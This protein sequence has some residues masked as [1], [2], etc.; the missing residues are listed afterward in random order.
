MPRHLHI[1]QTLDIK[2]SGGLAGVASLHRAML[3]CGIVSSLAYSES[4]AGL[5]DPPSSLKLRAVFGNRFYFGWASA[6]RLERAIR[7]AEIVH[8]HGLYTYMNFLAGKYCRKYGKVLVCHPHGSLGPTYLRRGRIKKSIVLWLFENRNIQ[9]LSAWRALTAAESDQIQAFRPGTEVIVVPNGVPIPSDVGRVDG[10]MAG[11]S[12]KADSRKKIFLFV[13]RIAYMKGLDILLD[14]WTQLGPQLADAELWIAG[15]DFDGTVQ[16]LRR[17]IDERGLGN[18]TLLGAVSE[19]QKHWLLRAADVF[20]LPSR[21]E[22]Q[23]SAILEAMAF[24]KPVLI[25]DTCFFPLAAASNAGLESGLTVAKI[26]DSIGRFSRMPDPTLR[27][28]SENARALISRHFD[29]RQTVQELDRQCS[30]IRPP[31][32]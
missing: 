31:R 22:G 4:G 19:E 12:V 17:T 24:G 16:L 3:D 20:V 15:P 8:I 25:T 23:S 14:A 28:M 5:P 32:S 2:R 27:S 21:G 6:S 26:A 11:L 30:E 10:S 7:E 13:S 9:S 18:V 29:I 1:T